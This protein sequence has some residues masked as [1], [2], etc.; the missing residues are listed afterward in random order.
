MAS[1]DKD[2]SR[3]IGNGENYVEREKEGSRRLQ[4]D[5]PGTQGSKEWREMALEGMLSD[6]R[7]ASREAGV[8]PGSCFNSRHQLT[9][10][11]SE[12]QEQ[13]PLESQIMRLM[14]HQSL[15]TA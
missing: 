12:S 6:L 1:G 10:D 8:A 9:G 4:A 3:K 14:R 5:D 7:V 15:F 11:R 2:P 13:L